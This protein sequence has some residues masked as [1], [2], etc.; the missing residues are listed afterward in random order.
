MRS[1]LARRALA[2]GLLSLLAVAGCGVQP[3]DAIPAG[4]PPSGFV[5]PPRKIILYLVKDGRLRMVTR[6][7]RRLPPADTLALLAAKPTA[8]ERARGLTTEVPP[9][10]APFSLAA[11]P[12]GHVKV[13]LSTPAGD[14]STLALDQI[15]CTVAA[16]APESRVQITVA[17]AGQSVG[18]RDCPR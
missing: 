5:A 6:P 9:E 4:D 8:S 13:T 16:M 17:G 12:T 7:D 11:E 14:L 3:S 1:G 10:A 18:P 15:V 2:A